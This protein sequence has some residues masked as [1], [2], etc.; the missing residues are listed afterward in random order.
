MHVRTPATLIGLL[1]SL[2]GC[3]IASPALAQ[4]RAEAE[5]RVPAAELL[6]RGTRTS[7]QGWR[8]ESPVQ[9]DSHLGRFV[10]QTDWGRIEAHGSE[11]ALERIGEMPVIPQLDSISRVDV[12]ANA[13][14]TSAQRTGEAVVRVVTDPVGTV[15]GLPS[16]IARL[17]RRTA[18]RV[19]DVATSVGDAATRQRESTTG[20]G[21]AGE[22]EDDG[23]RPD[24]LVDFGRELAGVN[25]ARRELAQELGI[26]PYTRNP[27]IQER[28][29]KLAWAAVAGGFSMKAALGSVGGFAGD[30]LSVTTRLDSL[31]WEAS[32][33]EIR[34]VLEK[35]LVERGI[36]PRRAREF[37]RNG[38]FTPTQ[39]VALVEALES[40]GTPRGEADL[41]DLATGIRSEAHARFLV[42]QLRM[43]RRHLGRGDAVAEFVVLDQ[44]VAAQ[45]RNGQYLIA[46]PVDRLSW[47]EDL[48]AVAGEAGGLP[49]NRR[50]VVSGQVSPLA[51]RELSRAGFTV[52]AGA[53]RP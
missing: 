37:L 49:R 20:N 22:G 38:T 10:F 44:G 21:A 13:L 24:P 3:A 39:Q 36:E 26:D 42:N 41:L 27:L 33:E 19:R 17:V 4:A 18:G 34:R 11:I 5:P 48:R 50:V 29:E 16:G 14:A 23:S 51:R 43:L 15:Q 28:L 8:V 30:A 31:V 47:T 9:L 35:R 52:V 7:G 46:L 1:A 12:F 25:R 45:T 2:L 32:P 40:L 6:P 53:G